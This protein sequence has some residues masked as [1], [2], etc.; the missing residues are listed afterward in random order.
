MSTY[1]IYYVD[2]GIGKQC[3]IP[4]QDF[5]LGTLFWLNFGT[6]LSLCHPNFSFST[7]NLSSKKEG[8]KNWARS[9]RSYKRRTLKCAYNQ[10]VSLIKKSRFK[11]CL[12]TRRVTK[13]DALVLATLR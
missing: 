12:K 4:I 13:R 2:M 8:K 5:T 7:L 6:L 9:L 11:V 3:V 10:D 1:Y